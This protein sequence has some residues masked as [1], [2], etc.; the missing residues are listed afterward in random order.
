MIE[1]GKEALGTE[2]F[3]LFLCGGISWRA[4]GEERCLGQSGGGGGFSEWEWMDGW[5]DGSTLYA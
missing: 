5:M 3:C 4:R 2:F 1:R